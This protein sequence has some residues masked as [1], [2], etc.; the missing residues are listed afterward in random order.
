MD[1][2]KTDAYY[3]QKMLKD[4]KFIIANTD[5]LTVQELEINEIQ[6]FFV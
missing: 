1:N 2:I 4:V 3:L 6:Y 5:N